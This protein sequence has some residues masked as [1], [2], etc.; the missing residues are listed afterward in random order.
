[1]K[2]YNQEKTKILTDYDLTL[3]KLV[4]D[5]IMIMHHD[6]VSYQPAVSVEEKI[7]EI[8]ERG[9]IVEN[10]HGLWAEITEVF[11]N[12]ARTAV[13]IEE[14]PAVP[15]KEAYDEYED[16][17]VYIP[18]TE[19]ELEKQKQEKYETRVVELLRKKYSLNQELAILRQRDNKQEEYAA[20]NAY[21]EECKATAKAEIEI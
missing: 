9:G 11:E 19:E 4:G 1:M 17:A 7:K 12:G 21:A 13:L 20:Y 6:A 2:V 3:G 16:I 5:K 18:Y 8:K 10:S 14:T 15:A